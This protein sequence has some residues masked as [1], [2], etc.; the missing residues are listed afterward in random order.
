MWLLLI[1]IWSDVKKKEKN[2]SDFGWI[3]FQKVKGKM[4]QTLFIIFRPQ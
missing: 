1:P 4:I 2:K 3:V